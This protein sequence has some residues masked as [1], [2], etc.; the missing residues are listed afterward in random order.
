MILTTKK[1][2]NS[3]FFQNLFSS[4]EYEKIMS[5]LAPESRSATWSARRVLKMVREQARQGPEDVQRML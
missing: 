2:F 4:T 1:V 5:T 3:F